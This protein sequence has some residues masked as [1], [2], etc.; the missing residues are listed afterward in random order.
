MGQLTVNTYVQYKNVADD[1]IR[2][3]DLW[4]WKQLSHNRCPRKDV[5]V[6]FFHSR[7]K[8]DPRTFANIFY[9][10]DDHHKHRSRH[11][12]HRRRRHHRRRHHHR[13][14]RCYLG[15]TRMKTLSK[16]WPEE[17]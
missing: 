16:G 7:F 14:S 2:T 5:F 15:A 12:H 11:H 9:N 17:K 3:V 1:W 6:K 13:R 8:A 4:Y 10:G